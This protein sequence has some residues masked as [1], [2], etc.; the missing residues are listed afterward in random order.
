M[1]EYIKGAK[2]W[3]GKNKRQV[4][5]SFS[6]PYNAV[7]SSKISGWIK[8]VLK[9]VIIDTEMFKGHSTL[10]ASTSKAGL[11]GLSVT[12]ILERGFGVMLQTG[13]S[14]IT[15]RLSL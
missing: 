12:D 11:A 8:N 3:C 1:E 15:V 9:E 10:S 13:N 14:F 6:K 4:L 7:V 2:V 5:L